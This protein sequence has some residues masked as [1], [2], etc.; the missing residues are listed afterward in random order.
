MTGSISYSTMPSPLGELLLTRVDAGLTGIYMKAQ[1]YGQ[2]PAGDWQRD[3]V[4][5]EDAREQLRGYFEG[6]LRDFT[7]PLAAQGTPFQQAV[8][9]ALRDIPFGETIS[10]GELARRIGKPNASRAVGLANGHNPISIVVPCHR[11]IG[12]QR[13][14]HRLRRRHRAQALA[15]GPRARPRAGIELGL[16]A[17]AAR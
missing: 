8:W 2:E 12:A 16:A 6:G 5:L 14:R 3:D 15:A 9:R 1:K 4:A 17:R 13:R 10:Y 11:V 7:L